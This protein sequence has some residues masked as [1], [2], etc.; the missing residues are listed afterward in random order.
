ML[1]YFIAF[2]FI[3]FEVKIS[4]FLIIW[5]LKKIID[6]LHE[7]RIKILKIELNVTILRYMK[8]N[9]IKSAKVKI[10]K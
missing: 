5:G 9:Q 2:Y 7:I 8:S 3:I 4:E 1:F 10:K 6:Q